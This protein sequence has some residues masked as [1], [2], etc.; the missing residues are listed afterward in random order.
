VLLA[1]RRSA[2]NASTEAQQQ[3]FSLVIAAPEPI[4][5]RFRG[6][7]LAAMLNTAANLRV[8]ASWDTETTSTVVALRTLARRAHAMLKEARELQKAIRI[9][10]RSSRP[11]P[12]EEFGAGPIF[13]ATVPCAWWHRARIHSEAAFAM[14]AG[15]APIPANSGQVTNR[16]RLNRYGDRQLNRRCTS[17]SSPASAMRARPGT[18][19]PAA[20]PRARP[21]A[22]SNAVSRATSPATSTAY[23]KVARSRLEEP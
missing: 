22:R 9:I 4:R 20:P 16:Y 2:I 12:L 19:L 3:V 6:Q 14:L 7:K 1:A 15:V 13:A 8:H 11:D 21:A 23:S 18:T 17:S 10:V 5:A